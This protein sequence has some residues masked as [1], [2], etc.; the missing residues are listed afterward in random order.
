MGEKKHTENDDEF[1]MKKGKILFISGMILFVIAFSFIFFG[2]TRIHL[3]DR[4]LI[5]GF[6][7]CGTLSLVLLVKS[8][9]AIALIEIIQIDKKYRNKPLRQLQSVSR[10]AVRKK[11]QA[12]NFSLYGGYYRKKKFSFLR[13][14]IT[15]YIKL[16]DCSD[17]DQTIEYELD[18]FD[19]I[20]A[21][22][23]NRCLILFLY[24]DRL[25]NEIRDSL[26]NYGITALTSE[27]LDPH[28]TETALIIAA[29]KVSGKG[30]FLDI[31]GKITTLYSH[32]C[33]TIR[34]LFHN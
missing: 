8:M 23:K 18:Q 3:S 10:E 7:V 1:F 33:K 31:E 19:T 34:K 29:D 25:T 21:R 4:I 11:M 22:D 14:S 20:H 12:Q 27:S 24:F 9:P 26:R 16:S 5:A 32:G 6:F 30:Y 13:D 28:S 15:Y 2:K 17:I